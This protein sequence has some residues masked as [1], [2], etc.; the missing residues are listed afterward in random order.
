MHPQSGLRLNQNGMN[1]DKP[2]DCCSEA[3]LEGKHK[4]GGVVSVWRGR[5][6]Y[7]EVPVMLKKVD[8]CI[9]NKF[10]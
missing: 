8:A 9:Q 3:A 1:K 5:S 7:P 4:G 2:S 6:Y 10:K